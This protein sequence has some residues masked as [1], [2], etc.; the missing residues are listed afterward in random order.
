MSFYIVF[1]MGGVIR[2]REFYDRK[3]ATSAFGELIRDRASAIYL[4]AE[5]I[6]EPI[7]SFT[8]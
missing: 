8:R 6:D 2:H 7:E 3:A 4:F 5:G 1:R